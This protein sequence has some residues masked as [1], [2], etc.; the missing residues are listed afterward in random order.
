MDAQ[1]TVLLR[2]LLAFLDGRASVSVLDLHDRVR[3]ALAAGPAEARPDHTTCH[4]Q[5]AAATRERDAHKTAA[6][7]VAALYERLEAIHS[8]TTAELAAAREAH[9]R[10]HVALSCVDT[11]VSHATDNPESD[12]EDIMRIARAALASTPRPQDEPPFFDKG[13]LL[14]QQCRKLPAVC[15]GAYEG[16]G[17]IALACDTCCGHGCEDGWCVRLASTP[18]KGGGK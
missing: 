7:S 3:A 9:D 18:P 16:P 12:I 10:L 14:C 5:L 8:T 17:P 11:I 15:V 4:E 2:D 1:V 6:D 13:V